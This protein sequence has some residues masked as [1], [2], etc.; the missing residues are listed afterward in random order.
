ML[1][2]RNKKNSKIK[3]NK[4]KRINQLGNILSSWNQQQIIYLNGFLIKNEIKFERTQFYWS[5]YLYLIY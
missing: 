1:K 4:N 2:Y 5:N 3:L